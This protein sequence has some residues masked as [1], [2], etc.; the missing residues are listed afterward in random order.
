MGAELSTQVGSDN[1]PETPPRRD[2][3]A[4]AEFI[5]SGKCEG[6]IFLYGA[7]TS[8]SASILDFRTPG[9]GLYSNLQTLNPPHPEAVFDINLCRTNPQPSYTL[10]KSL[11][12][13]QFTQTVT[14]AF[15]L[16]TAKK[17]LPQK[18][19]TQNI[20][21]LE[22]AA[23]VPPEKLSCIDCHTEYPA[24]MTKKHLLAG[25]VP[26]LKPNIVFFGESLPREFHMGL[27]I[28]EEAGSVVIMGSSLSAYPFAALPGQAREGAI[29]VLI[30]HQR[31]GG[32]WWLGG[33]RTF[34]GRVRPGG[35]K[36]GG[37]G[38]TDEL[39]E[40]W[41]SVG[42]R[43][44]KKAEAEAESSEDTSLRAFCA[45]LKRLPFFIPI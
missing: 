31:V 33:R 35:E 1:P 24:D 37:A 18:C 44:G 12:P 39:E 22:R 16:L 13:G 15:I 34:A 7:G 17:Y 26:Q 25:S 42:G 10:A 4:V 8:T 28:V 27:R 20:D 9:I 29:R 11:N 41:R 43:S 5:R 6:I 32:Y 23:G 40:V 45:N 3:P 14:H 19:F 21:T 2:I 36:A 38:W 30:N